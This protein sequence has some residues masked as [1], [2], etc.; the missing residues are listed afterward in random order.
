MEHFGVHC[1]WLKPNQLFIPAN[2]KYKARDYTVEADASS[3]S[4]FFAMAA[5]TK[6]KITLSAFSPK[7]LQGDLGFLQILKNMGCQVEWGMNE[8]TLK[9]MD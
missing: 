2:Q 7:S 4:Y 5:I 9:C 1:E 8:V 6:G 3:A